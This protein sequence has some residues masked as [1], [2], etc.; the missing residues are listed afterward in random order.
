[1]RILSCRVPMGTC[2]AATTSN[3]R[4]VGTRIIISGRLAIGCVPRSAP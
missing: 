2:N 1:L 4:S 3:G